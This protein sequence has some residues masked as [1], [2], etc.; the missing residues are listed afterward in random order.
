MQMYVDNAASLA[1][2]KTNGQ[3]TRKQSKGYSA[4]EKK[5]IK[6]WL[7]NSNAG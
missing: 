4:H 7:G 1:A 6:K 5:K 2:S 3:L